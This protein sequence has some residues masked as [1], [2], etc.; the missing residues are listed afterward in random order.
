MTCIVGLVEKGVVWMGGDSA[1]SG[2]LSIETRADQKVF[3]NGPMVF[4]FTSSFR[5]GQLLEHALHVPEQLPSRTD[6][7]YLVTDFV[8]AVRALYRERGFMGRD[9]ERDAGGTF[10]LG[11]R[12][13]LYTVCDDFQVARTLYPYAAVGCGAEL[14]LGA[15][16]VTASQKRDPAA[17]IKGALAAAAEFSAAV[18]APFHVVRFP[19]A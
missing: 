15:M 16:Y 14:A 4:G 10:L 11:Y 5:M 12:G 2:G 18:R 19:A 6:M 17:R 9:A 7:A 13:A 3:V 8:D 1:A